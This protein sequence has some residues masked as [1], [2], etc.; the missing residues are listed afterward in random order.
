MTSKIHIRMGTVEVDFEGTEDFIRD[1]LRGVIASVASLP[2]ATGIVADVPVDV[3]VSAEG[4]A[5]RVNG[6]TTASIAAKLGVD[7]EPE[8]VIAAAG[9]LAVFERKDT[10]TRQQLLEEMK[11]AAGYYKK[12]YRGNLSGAL[13]RLVSDGKLL[14]TSANTFSLAP[15]TKAD[16]SSKL[17]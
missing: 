9:R 11:S 7:S 2:K 17:A 6:L 5:P 16:L 12:S 10:Y 13:Q 8:L 15:A 1:D 3:P 14:E 4:V